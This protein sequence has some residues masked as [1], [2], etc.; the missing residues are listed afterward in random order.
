[1]CGRESEDEGAYMPDLERLILG[2][3]WRQPCAHTVEDDAPRKW[4]HRSA[5]ASSRVG[6]QPMLTPSNLTRL[7]DV[8]EEASSQ[9]CMGSRMYQLLMHETLSAMDC[10]VRLSERW[11]RRFPRGIGLSYKQP[12]HDKLVWHSLVE[13]TERKDNFMLKICWFQE[14]FNIPPSHTV[15]ETA[16]TCEDSMAPEDDHPEIE[17]LHEGEIEEAEVDGDVEDMM[18]KV[19][20]Q[21]TASAS[22]SSAAPR[23]EAHSTRAMHCAQ[24]RPRHG[25]NKAS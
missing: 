16:A 20:V 21:P 11:T 10:D 23:K 6:R 15:P 3:R 24:P 13:Q 5:P 22:S 17:I 7:S 19:P 14:T 2:F 8:V 4:K 25:K 12:S 1:M 9:L 18:M